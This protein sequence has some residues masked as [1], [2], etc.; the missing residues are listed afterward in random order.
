EA[1]PDS[2]QTWLARY[3]FR[4]AVAAAGAD[5]DLEKALTLAPREPD[6][7]LAAAQRAEA[8][9]DVSAARDLVRQCREMQPNNADVVKTFVSLQVRSGQRAEALATLASAIKT[10]PESWEL[11]AQSAE[12]L[13]DDG[14]LPEATA[15][16]EEL[17][18]SD[19]PSPLVE[20]L[21]ARLAVTH[22][23]WS[24]A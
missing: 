18:E 8:K 6:I 11:C 20:Y 14:K 15:R 9:G 21:Q 1:N 24:D 3:Q 12:L 19:A 4:Q 13:L 2:Y 22:G 10:M 16:I 17:R 5:A 23:K 7:L